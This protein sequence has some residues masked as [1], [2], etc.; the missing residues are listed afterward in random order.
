MPNT[1]RFPYLFR[2][3][4][5]D[6]D[7]LLFNSYNFAFYGVSQASGNNYQWPSPPVYRFA[8]VN[9]YL[10]DL[11][12]DNEEMIRFVGNT[13]IQAEMSIM[14]G[15]RH[16]FC[17]VYRLTEGQRVNSSTP[18]LTLFPF[19]I[20]RDKSNDR[21]NFLGATGVFRWYQYNAP[22]WPT[23]IE[24]HTLRGSGRYKAVW[25]RDAPRFHYQWPVRWLSGVAEGGNINDSFIGLEVAFARVKGRAQKHVYF[26][27]PDRS[28]YFLDD[29]GRIVLHR[30]GNLF[31]GA[32]DS[33]RKSMSAIY[34]LFSDLVFDKNGRLKRTGSP[35]IGNGFPN[36]VREAKAQRRSS[37]S[38][39]GA[40]EIFKAQ[41]LRLIGEYIQVFTDLIADVNAWGHNLNYDVSA[42]SRTLGVY[43]SAERIARLLNAY[44]PSQLSVAGLRMDEKSRL[45]GVDPDMRLRLGNRAQEVAECWDALCLRVEWMRRNWIEYKLRDQMAPFKSELLQP[46]IRWDPASESA[47]WYKQTY[48]LAYA[49]M[50]MRVNEINAQSFTGNASGRVFGVTEPNTQEP[51]Y[52]WKI[53]YQTKVTVQ[54]PYQDLASWGTYNQWLHQTAEIAADIE[55]SYLSWQQNALDFIDLICH[56]FTILDSVPLAGVRR[57]SGKLPGQLPL[58]RQQQLNRKR[59]YPRAEETP[60]P[61][62]ED[63][64]LR[65]IPK[66]TVSLPEFQSYQIDTRAI[67]KRC[68]RDAR[69]QGEQDKF[70]DDEIDYDDLEDAQQEQYSQEREREERRK[71]RAQERPTRVYRNEIDPISSQDLD[72]ERSKMYEQIHNNLENVYDA[73][74]VAFTAVE[75]F[76]AVTA[77]PSSPLIVM[78][79][80]A[81]KAAH[82]AVKQVARRPIRRL[83]E[84]VAEEILENIVEY[85][86]EPGETRDPEIETTTNFQTGETH[87]RAYSPPRTTDTLPSTGTELFSREVFPKVV[88]FL[89]GVDA[90]EFFPR[91]G[92]VTKS[93]IEAMEA[94][95]GREL[96]QTQIRNI[97]DSGPD[98]PKSSDRW[99]ERRP[100]ERYLCIRAS[101]RIPRP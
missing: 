64:K 33:Y 18:M 96:E 14:G 81:R 24:R 85:E 59:V 87:V 8:R 90:V 58:T 54:E 32:F 83:A 76:V 41:L 31:H 53:D 49:D 50:M 17:V 25:V 52:S 37:Y 84:E 56:L 36:L 91:F 88:E 95:L 6:N 61:E 10:V 79:M 68:A 38:K 26:Q 70:D 55:H 72:S 82:Q 99:T 16:L 29:L 71:M 35:V 12:K 23:Y 3:V 67:V 42:Y 46:I 51:Y 2:V 19:H 98:R 4:K 40:S 28:N 62:G 63:G 86:L 73:V 43:I 89:F 11:K 60:R 39:Q 65:D 45:L 7:N 69:R 93:I 101:R 48:S 78:E 94:P 80:G 30:K 74:D 97:E 100:T 20:E 34:P 75:V 44:F 21:T 13:I 5:A 15:S 9:E 27:C 22:R 1:Q 77:P 47:S 92:D 57:A 66:P